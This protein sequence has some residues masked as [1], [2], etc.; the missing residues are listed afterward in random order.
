V[1]KIL[2]AFAALILLA[3]CG[4][5]NSIA[6]IT[7]EEGSGTRG[8]FAELFGVVDE[9]KNDA[10]AQSAEVTNNTAVM[11]LSVSEGKNA[12]G[13]ISLGS[14]NDSVKAL[15]IDG[16]KATAENVKDG[17]YPVARPFIIGTNGEGS[18]GA[19]HFIAFILSK[20]GQDIVEKKGYIK[21]DGSLGDLLTGSPGDLV[22]G[23]PSDLVTSSHSDLLTSSRSELGSPSDPG[24][25]REPVTLT[26][27]GS[28][29]VTP[30]MEAL[31]EAYVKRFPQADI[32]IQQSDSSTGISAVLEGVSDIGMAS[33]ALK[34][35]ELD[36]GVVP[37]VI[38]MDGIAV[39]VNKENPVE[40]LSKEE[41][42]KIFMGETAEW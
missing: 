16:V 36:K 40:G 5:K 30:V 38:A 28:S 27:A 35:S 17:S 2:T 3:S 11:T 24:S 33:R 42:R 26:V 22:T 10:I 25:L 8:A 37:T 39:I 18:A 20:E 21:V 4:Q 34:Q 1:K 19:R 31:A 14:L 9:N 29:S 6:V 23:S 7:R 32:E 12:I 13:Y 15:T 41:V